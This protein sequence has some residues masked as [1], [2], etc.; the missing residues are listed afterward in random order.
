MEGM[1][2]LAAQ[3]ILVEALS[4]ELGKK[5]ARPSLYE[6]HISW[7][8]VTPNY[9]Y[10]FKKAI[11]FDFIDYSTL[12]RRQFYCNEELRLNRRLAPELYLGIVP[13]T[14]TAEHPAMEVD[15]PPIEYAVKMRSFPQEALWSYRLEHDLLTESEIDEL[16]SGLAAFHQRAAPSS[17]SDFGTPAALEA[18]AREN[19]DSV[20]KLLDGASG[21]MLN[22]PG[23]EELREWDRL[24]RDRLHACFVI[25]K[26]AGFVRECHGDL[27]GAN[28]LTLGGKVQVFDCIE[29]NDNL[30]WIDVM[31]DLAF[32]CMDLSF[33]RRTDLANRLRNRYLEES[34]D[35][36]GLAVLRYYEIHRALVRSK[37]ALLRA[38]QPPEENTEAQGDAEKFQDALSMRS[39]GRRYFDF[40]VRLSKPPAT[41]LMITHGFS[42]CGKTTWAKKIVELAGAIQLRSDVERKRMH[43]L[44][45]TT[46]LAAGPAE[47]LYEASATRSTYERLRD[48][49]KCVIAA[50]WPAIVDASFLQ[51]EYRFMF[52]RLAE[53]MQV[54]FF[55][56]DLR[57]DTET[58]R[59]RIS[60][61]QSQGA[62]ASDAG[63]EILSHQ[64]SRHDPLTSDESRT[65]ITVRPDCSADEEAIRSV[66]FP[67]LEA[68]AAASSGN[69]IN[70]VGQACGSALGS[71]PEKA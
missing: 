52:R 47:K 26:Q 70:D 64:L 14:G 33:L 53:E 18:V 6:T 2:A 11:R 57:A 17:M 37:V 34:G 5:A 63:L 32:A 10:K 50:G 61:R 7:V 68:L 49:A 20:A 69:V 16:A 9:A 54:S 66:C 45:P 1:R 40:A 25:R 41:A 58:L 31:N 42:G 23:I 46:H 28:I 12:E 15:G 22:C 71:P 27:H 13:I 56:F 29:F 67:V 3:K 51:F 48:L 36:G 21:N 43:G 8:L 65:T 30:R 60:M 39:L 4:L 59:S 24:Q 19:I 44:A 62:D 35:Y 55:I 38:R